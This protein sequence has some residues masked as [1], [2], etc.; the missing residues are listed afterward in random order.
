[1]PQASW[2][3]P[4]RVAFAHIGTQV[5]NGPFE[6]LALLTDRWPD[7]R[8]PNFVR[9]RSACRAALDGRRTPEEARLQFEQAV[10]EAQSHLN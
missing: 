1:M 8:G 4:V 10:S 2:E 5:V 6:A 9:A 3:K 7:M